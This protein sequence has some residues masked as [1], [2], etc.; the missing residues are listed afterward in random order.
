MQHPANVARRQRISRQASRH[1][2]KATYNKEESPHAFAPGMTA[3]GYLR[4]FRRERRTTKKTGTNYFFALGG[5]LI[6]P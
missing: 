5:S 2:Q 4:Y 6:A 3:F 1:W